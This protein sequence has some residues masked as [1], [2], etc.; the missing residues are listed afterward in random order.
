METEKR[1]LFTLESIQEEKFVQSD[2]AILAESLQVQY[3]IE[4]EVHPGKECVVVRAGV[5][6]LVEERMACE[7]VLAVRFSIA[8]YP[9]VVSIDESGKKINFTSNIIPTFLGM[10]FGA[11]RGALYEKVKGTQLEAYPLPPMA[12]ADLE[13]MNHFK[14]IS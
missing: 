12:L 1:V 9:S 7:M 13:K 3:L 10:T 14:V 2:A 11:L 4:T 5:R 8:D 6:Y